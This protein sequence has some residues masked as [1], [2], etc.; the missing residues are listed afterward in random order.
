MVSILEIYYREHSIDARIVINLPGL[1][2]RSTTENAKCGT[3]AGE[4][5]SIHIVS[6]SFF[7][8]LLCV[9]VCAFSKLVSTV[10]GRGRPP[11]SLV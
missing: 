1:Q 3:I 11:T 7:L 5:F 4:I 2:K 9:W 10:T 8:S 6:L